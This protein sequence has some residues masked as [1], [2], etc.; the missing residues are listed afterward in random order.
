MC[1]PLQRMK[2]KQAKAKCHKKQGCYEIGNQL[3][4]Y[5]K[6]KNRFNEAVSKNNFF[7]GQKLIMFK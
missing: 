7:N 3:L 6:I 2:N 5:T 4:H 1:Q